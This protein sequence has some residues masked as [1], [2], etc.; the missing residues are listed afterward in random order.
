MLSFLHPFGMKDHILGPHHARPSL[1]Q[2]IGFPVPPEHILCLQ[3]QGYLCH[4]GQD[5]GEWWLTRTLSQY[6]CDGN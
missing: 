2:A 5:V 6:G 3:H 1:A 4:S